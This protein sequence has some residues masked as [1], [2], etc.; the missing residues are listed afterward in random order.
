MNAIEAAIQLK[1]KA[2]EY[3][4]KALSD[5]RHPAGK[6]MFEVI[7]KDEE[8]HLESLQKLLNDITEDIDKLTPI[9]N[10]KN[11]LESIKEDMRVRTACS[12]DDVEAF[13]IAMD[14]EKECLDF[15]RKQVTKSNSDYERTLLTKIAREEEE[16]FKIF[17]NTYEF[18]NDTGN[19]YMWEEHSIVEGG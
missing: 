2:I 19:W 11:A 8:L 5:C 6:R 9:K 16:H 1:S 10:V 4:K 7:L 12:F 3:Y 17:A 13:R 14:V 15:F 18:L